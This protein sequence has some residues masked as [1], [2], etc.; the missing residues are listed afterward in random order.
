MGSGWWIQ[1]KPFSVYYHP[2]FAAKGLSSFGA[3]QLVGQ[4]IFTTGEMFQVASLF[5]ASAATIF[6]AI[7]WIIG[8]KFEKELVSKIEQKRLEMGE[9]PQIEKMVQSYLPGIDLGDL[10]SSL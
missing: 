3:G 5:T 1:V 7:Y 4:G 9:K 10:T 6:Y 2:Y 8:R